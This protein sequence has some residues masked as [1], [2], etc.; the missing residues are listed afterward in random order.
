M[1][2][3]HVAHV[4]RCFSEA[5]VGRTSLM[6][7]LVCVCFNPGMLALFV[8]LFECILYFICLISTLVQLFINIAG[9]VLLSRR[10]AMVERVKRTWDAHL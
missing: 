8:Y 2:E 9:G 3:S 1:M 7:V 10:Y 5:H 4:S 6:V